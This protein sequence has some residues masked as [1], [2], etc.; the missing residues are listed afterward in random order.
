MIKFTALLALGT[1]LMFLWST[2][3]PMPFAVLVL[4]AALS[5]LAVLGGGAIFA[6]LS[7]KYSDEPGARPRSAMPRCSA[8]SRP[9]SRHG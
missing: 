2:I 5:G 7:E 9:S 4:F 8:C 1:A 3:T 6:L